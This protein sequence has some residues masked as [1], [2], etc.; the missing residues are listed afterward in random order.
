MMARAVH[1]VAPR[2]VELRE[3]ELPDP[4][5]GRILVATEWSGISSGTELLAYRGEVD[6][7]LPLDETLG[8]LA[9]TFAYPFRYGYSAVGRVV[10]PAGPFREGQRVFAFHPHQERFVTDAG[11]AVPVDD[12]DPRAATLYPMVETALQV[13][14]D[15]APRLGETVVVA[16]LGAVGILVAALLGRTGAVVLGSEPEPARRA[17]AAAFGVRA[18]DPGAAPEAVAAGTGGRGADLVVEA[19]G[20]PQALAA[21][22]SLLAHEGTAL[23]CSWYGTKP[24]TLPLGAAFHRRRLAL[25]STQVSTLPAALSARWDRRRRAELAWRLCRE[26]PLSALATHAFP[27][28]RAAE[29]YACAD[30]KDDGLIHAA[31]RY[32]GEADA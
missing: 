18:V 27:F 17:A 4:S 14:L 31:L 8:A 12:L 2:R 24:V 19:S 21:A 10:R 11:D 13:A 15:A 22:L 20:N 16:G 30:H 5:E 1:F 3:V 23:V 28:E 32:Q 26:L 29:A 6:P 9:G 25:R 7:E